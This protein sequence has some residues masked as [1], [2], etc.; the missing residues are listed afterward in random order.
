[1]NIKVL[2]RDDVT[3][4]LQKKVSALYKQLN[5][6]NKQRPLSEIF[7]ENNNVAFVVCKEGDTLIG[8]AL[9][10]TY[11]VI[12]GYRGL[13]EDVVVDSQFRGQGIGRK[14][15][16]KLLEKAKKIGLDEVLLF[17]GHHR[18]AAI[19][20]YTGLGFELRKS[21]VYNIRFN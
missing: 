8:T 6:T 14:M 17:T 12:S 20:L 7:A 4:D 21:G 11:K 13:V 18:K 2:E 10:S 5:A 15:M 16:E 3:P 1:M 9:L 19:K